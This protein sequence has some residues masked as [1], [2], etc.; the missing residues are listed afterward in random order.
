[1]RL[2]ICFT[3]FG[4]YHVARLRALAGRLRDEGGRLVAYEVAGNEAKYPWRCPREEEPFEWVTLF[5]GSILEDLS[6][7]ACRRAITEALDRGQPDAVAIVGYARPESIAALRWAERH[8]R[9]TILMSESQAIDRP[10]VWWK[11][12][13]KR[14][15]VR[16]FDAALVG[17]PSHRD[18]LV[19]LGM[20][21]GR[22]ALGYNAVDH[23]AHATRAEALRSSGTRPDGIP[24]GPYFLA[25]SRFV[26][27]KDLPLLIRAF[28]RYRLEAAPGSAWDLV[29][30]G[31]GPERERI[32][33]VIAESGVEAFI[34]RPGF[35]QEEE[36]APWFA[37][38][39]A[40]VLPSRSEPWGLVVNE[41][42]ACGLPLIVSEA[43]GCAETLV[44][45]PSGTTGWRFPAGEETAL[46]KRLIEMA[47]LAAADRHAMGRRAREAAAPWGPARFAEGTMQALRWA[48][49]QAARNRKRSAPA[50]SGG[51]R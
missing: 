23:E 46:S 27:E 7:A 51:M 34:H 2:G 43:A 3:N 49:T 26:A 36:L 19:E 30:C 31:D 16:R 24:P 18:Y 38:A 47:G 41:A 21:A 32:A 6:G 12:S 50:G 13:I 4:P 33:Q 11:E 17:G 15:R 37:F 1:M 20:P 40:F 14:A 29:L 35:L 45:E 42:A 28:A 39:S 25:V 5:P 44:P 22:I 9:P 10:R 48:W 8:G